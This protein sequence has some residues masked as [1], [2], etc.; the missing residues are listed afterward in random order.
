[1][2]A[3]IYLRI[4]SDPTGKAAGVQRQE[5]DCRDL[6][7]RLGWDITE[8]YRENDTS[9]VS[10]KGRP[11]FRRMLADLETG[12]IN[13]VI[14]W[15]PDRLYRRAVDLMPLVDVCK[16]TN[17]QIAT[18]TAGDL[19]LSTPSGRM[20]AGILA[21]IATYEGEHKSER[22]KRSI[23]QSRQAG[24]FAPSGKRLFGYT[25]REKVERPD[26]THAYTGEHGKVIPE[27][28]ETVR[29]LFKEILAGATVTGLCTKL[30]ARGIYTTQGNEWRTTNLKT[31][32]LNP[33]LAGYA[34][35]GKEIIGDGNHETIVDRDTWEQAR[36]M[37]TSH[38]SGWKN[39]RVSLLLGLA[40]CGKCGT[41]LSSGSVRKRRT[42]RCS[43]APGVGGCEGVSVYAEPV[44]EIVEL[45]VKALLDQPETWARL[46]TLQST[47]GASEAL[48]EIAALEAR[49]L[50]LES[51][52]ETPGVPVETILRSITGTKIRLDEL[53]ESLASLTP[54][55]LPDRGGEWPDDLG[56]RRKLVALMVSRV[57]IEPVQNH[58]TRGVFNPERVKIERAEL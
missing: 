42:Y 49:L 52:L 31:Y 34:T 23:L 33:R 17:A 44:E 37:M 28:A 47:T 3:G 2:K 4:S 38:R 53:R 15:H 24:T 56:R 50:E 46:A 18:V 16:Q 19:D 10:A 21:Q 8:T 54:V 20:L 22:Y 27:E 40:F 51:S 55:Q 35:I 1:M 5:E 29:W 45:Y 11:H 58:A 14:A 26:G 25:A 57:V 6:A 48:T 13:A 9:A 30:N 7:D 36:A 39:A 43:A 12:H 32:L 41:R